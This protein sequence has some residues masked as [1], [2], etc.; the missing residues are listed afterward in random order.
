MFH[1]PPATRS[2]AALIPS[3]A[4]SGLPAFPPAVIL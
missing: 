3:V 4:L 2:V 1:V